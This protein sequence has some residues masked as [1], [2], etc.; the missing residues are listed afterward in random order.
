MINEITTLIGRFGGGFSH[1]FG[2]PENGKII[3]E[4]VFGIQLEKKIGKRQKF[5]GSMQ[6][7]SPLVHFD[8]Y[9]LRSQAA[10]ELL[11]D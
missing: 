9:R 3:P 4:A 11:L 10:L 8:R 7:A 5:L 1:E 2:G 6:Y